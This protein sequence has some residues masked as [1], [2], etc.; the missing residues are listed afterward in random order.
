MPLFGMS[1][2]AKLELNRATTFLIVRNVWKK[3]FGLFRC[4]PCP[5][6]LP[7]WKNPIT[8][9]GICLLQEWGSQHT[10]SQ[11]CRGWTT[12]SVPALYMDRRRACRSQQWSIGSVLGRHGGVHFY[13]LCDLCGLDSVQIP[14]TTITGTAPTLSMGDYT[15][16]TS[17]NRMAVM[18]SGAAKYKQVSFFSCSSYS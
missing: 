9:S 2:H 17:N 6:A 8:E 11:C 14:T 15:S 16:S 5:R 13:P 1:A 10:P 18:G 7:C 3:A 4:C 12:T